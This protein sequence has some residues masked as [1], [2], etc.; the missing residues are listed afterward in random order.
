L[1]FLA[2]AAMI[3]DVVFVVAQG[4]SVAAICVIVIFARTAREFLSPERRSKKRRQPSNVR[5]IVNELQV[6]F[7]SR[8]YAVRAGGRF[9]ARGS[10]LLLDKEMPCHLDSTLLGSCL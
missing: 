10:R 9:D 2:C 7:Q 1:F 6:K 4:V 8:F 5:Q 3:G